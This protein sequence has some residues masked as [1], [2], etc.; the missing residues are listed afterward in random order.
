MSPREDDSA[1]RQLLPDPRDKSEEQ[2]DLL[3]LADQHTEIG[4]SENALVPEPCWARVKR[5]WET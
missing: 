1:E 3:L 5:G 2:D 4:D